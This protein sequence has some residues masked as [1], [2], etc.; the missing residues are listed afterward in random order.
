[1]YL[2]EIGEEGKQQQAKGAGHR[3]VY[4]ETTRKSSTGLTLAWM[5][6]TSL[7]G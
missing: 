3:H 7:Y 1:M 2:G 6:S 4:S 5:V